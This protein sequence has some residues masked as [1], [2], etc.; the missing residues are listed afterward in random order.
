M[1]SR[2][3]W[4]PLNSPCSPAGFTTTGS[5]VVWCFFNLA[6]PSRGDE[7]AA[8]LGLDFEHFEGRIEHAK[9]QDGRHGPPPVGDFGV[10][11]SAGWA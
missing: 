1:L 9:G 7:F 3:A 2:R 4:L 5:F 11:G 10:R 6:S 8:R